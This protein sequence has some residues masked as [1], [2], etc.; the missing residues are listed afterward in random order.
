MIM[1]VEKSDVE[2]MVNYKLEMN[3]FLDFFL[4]YKEKGY[5]VEFIGNEIIEGIEIFKIKFVKELIMV[6]GKEE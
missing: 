5:I 6:D 1:V 4:N 3:D 2:F